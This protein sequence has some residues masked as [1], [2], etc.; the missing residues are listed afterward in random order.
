MLLFIFVSAVGRVIGIDIGT[1]LCSYTHLCLPRASRELA[2]ELLRSFV[3]LLVGDH[4]Q[5]RRCV[6]AVFENKTHLY[7]TSN[8]RDILVTLLTPCISR[9][10]RAKR[11]VLERSHLNSLEK[12]WL[13]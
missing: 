9:H 1:G 7:V 13:R 11:L 4:S 8:I 10:H 3:S 6:M 12:R 5:I 2:L